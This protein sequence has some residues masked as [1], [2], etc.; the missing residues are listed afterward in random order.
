M[1]SI[2]KFSNRYLR[3]SRLEGHLGI[4]DCLV[5]KKVLEIDIKVEIN[6][7]PEATNME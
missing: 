7:N 5:T 6:E 1:V 4:C 2:Q 3:N